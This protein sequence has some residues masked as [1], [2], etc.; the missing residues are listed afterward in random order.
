MRK[1]SHYGS[2][3]N[4]IPASYHTDSAVM[5]EPRTPEVKRHWDEMGVHRADFREI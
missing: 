1:L 5:D 2:V 4:N 3:T